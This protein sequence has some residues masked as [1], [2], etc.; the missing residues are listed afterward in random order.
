MR[1]LLVCSP[2][3]HLQQMLALGPAWRGHDRAWVTLPGAD[4]SSLLADEQVTIAHSP[5]NRNVKNLARNTG[6][7]WRLLR[8]RRPDAILSTGAGI[9]VPFFLIGKLL[10]IRTVYVESVTR[11]ESLS[12]SGRM[13]YRLAGRFFVQW[14]AVAEHFKKAEYHGGIL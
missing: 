11:T 14:P 10:G 8:R 12:L 3:G 1:V 2:G 9:A 13:V 5:T 6:L 4:V 7:A